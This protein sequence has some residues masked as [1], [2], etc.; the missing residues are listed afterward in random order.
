MA[1]I[2]ELLFWSGMRRPAL[3]DTLRHNLQTN[4]PKEVEKLSSSL[5]QE[6]SDEDLVAM[7]VTR[8]QAN[9]LVLELAGATGSAQ[10]QPI[11]IRDVFGDQ[12]TV[13]GLRIIQSIPFRGDAALFELQPNTWDTS[14]PRGEVRG[15]KV[16][17]GM[18]VAESRSEDAIR[19]IEETR[20]DLQ[21][22]ID[23]QAPTIAEHNAAIPAA[24]LAA[25]QRRRTILGKASDIASRLSGGG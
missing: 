16:V 24:A 6:K 18:E 3:S 15:S 22:Y 13:N 14:P 25:I 2:G 8:C 11:T 10:P 4:V 1:V 17:I 19:Y 9:P 21:K 12:I 23:W 5:L 20:A 7:I